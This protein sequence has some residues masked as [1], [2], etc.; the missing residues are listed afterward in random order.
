[1]KQL[2]RNHL[3]LLENAHSRLRFLNLVVYLNLKRYALV[4]PM[5]DGMWNL[6]QKHPR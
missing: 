3:L 6:S 1:M 4:N 5:C 2:L